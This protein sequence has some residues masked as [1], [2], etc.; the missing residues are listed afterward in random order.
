MLNFPPCPA[1][2]PFCTTLESLWNLDCFDFVLSAYLVEHDASLW[3]T[4][5]LY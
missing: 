3:V 4:C 1:R 5:N 2:T